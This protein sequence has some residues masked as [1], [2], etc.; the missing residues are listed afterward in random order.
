MSVKIL[1]VHDDFN[2]PMNG[3]AEYEGEKVWFDRVSNEEQS[4]ERSYTIKRVDAT[5]IECVLEPDHKDYCEIIGAPLKHGDPIK[6]KRSRQMVTKMDIASAIPPGEES[7]EVQPRVLSQTKRF[8]HRY[9]PQCLP[10]EIITTIKESQFTNY[11]VP[12]RI[13]ME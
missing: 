7:L 4:E 12:R 10:G 11:F 5:L 9:D 2:G 3:L 13:E 8:V 6:V 1:W